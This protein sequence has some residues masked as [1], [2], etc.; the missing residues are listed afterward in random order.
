MTSMI[1]SQWGDAERVSV[2]VTKV[3]QAN[4]YLYFCVFSHANVT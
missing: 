4:I 2:S 3:C 1:G